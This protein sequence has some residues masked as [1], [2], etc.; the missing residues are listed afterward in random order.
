MAIIGY[1][2]VSQL[3]DL[4]AAG[5]ETIY[6]EKI[7]GAH[8]GRPQLPKLKATLKAGD[9]VPVTKL[10]RLGRGTREL[11][12]RISEAGAA[13]RSLGDPLWDTSG[14]LARTHQL[15]H[16]P[17][18]DNVCRLVFIT[19]C[20]RH[21]RVRPLSR[22]IVKDL[23]VVLQQR[24]HHLN[25]YKSKTAACLGQRFDSWS[26]ECSSTLFV[27]SMRASRTISLRSL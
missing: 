15:H 6:R 9:V 20:I 11:P 8:A 17:A 10:D 21:R 24:R 2:R 13:F 7:S 3:E 5:A 4:K 1:A 18:S 22:P 14:S 16:R 23:L 26:H 25:A 12:E 19:A 27:S